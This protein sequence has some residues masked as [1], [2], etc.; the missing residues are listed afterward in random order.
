MLLF[1]FYSVFPFKSY[2]I[3]NSDF[4]KTC[5]VVNSEVVIGPGCYHS[6]VNVKLV[7]LHF[8]NYLLLRKEEIETTAG[9]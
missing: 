3:V 8:P 4:L 1:E 6:L 5:I 9:S 7:I 2:V